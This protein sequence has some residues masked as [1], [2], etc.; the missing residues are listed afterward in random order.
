MRRLDGKAPR[1]RQPPGFDHEAKPVLHN[2]LNGS[3]HCLECQGRCTI[4]DPT[5]AA[6]T[7]IV[8]ELIDTYNYTH[9]PF[10]QTVASI[11]GRHGIE[12]EAMLK[13]AKEGEVRLH[14]ISREG[15]MV[16]GQP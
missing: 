15:K 12:V 3:A 4:T 16:A 2:H 6:L 14:H 13:A 8:R 5:Q 7:S 10:P 11:L 1:P 9:Q